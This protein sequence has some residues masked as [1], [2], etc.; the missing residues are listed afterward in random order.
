M[1]TPF[2]AGCS[3]SNHIGKETM[4]HRLCRAK[5]AF[6]D[7]D[8]VFYPGT[9]VVMKEQVINVNGLG[10]VVIPGGE[11]AK[12]RSLVDGQ[13][14]SFLRAMGMRIVFVTNESDA[15]IRPVLDKLNSLPSVK[16]GKWPPI[17]ASVHKIGDEKLEF[18]QGLLDSPDF[19]AAGKVSWDECLYMGDDIGDVRVMQQ[20]HA[21][22][23]LVVVPQ[24]AEMIVQQWAHIKT[25]RVGG[26][27]AI[28]DLA[29]LIVKVREVDPLTLDLK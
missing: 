21:H 27:G 2:M 15:F 11:M 28:R 17:I 14:I 9:A 7:I 8:G 26:C 13:G 5:V 3:V 23:G 24:Q 29:N 22:D 1:F 18:C 4:L 20:V 12:E 6:F 25:D 19:A 10:S 16:S